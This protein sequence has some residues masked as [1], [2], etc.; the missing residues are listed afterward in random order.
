M[1]LNDV[2][3]ITAVIR[4]YKN[5]S[6]TDQVKSLLKIGVGHVIVVINAPEDKGATRGFLG[7]IANNPQLT[8]V[9]MQ[10]DY[11][12]SNALNRGLM[13]VHINNLR[14]ITN[15]RFVLNVSI[16]AQFQAQHLEAMLDGMDD[17]RV[18]V[19][20]T[21]FE[22]VQEGHIVPLGQSYKHPR[23]TGMLI[24][25]EVARSGFDPFCDSV[26][27]MEDIYFLLLMIAL[28]DMIFLHLDLKVPLVIGKHYH[29][30]TK[31]GNERNAMNKI[32]AKA[33][34]FFPVETKERERIDDCIAA[35]GIDVDPETI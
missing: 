35:M 23:N 19:V 3:S 6:V 8:I 24:R 25:T 31:E 7:G 22:G 27:G 14:K 13:V 1:E 28:S 10:G 4:T 5:S 30:P 11:S 34:S 33:R 15:C 16:E 29:Q 17:P 18:G 20:G 32:I 21:S 2:K 9:D 12:W 26:G